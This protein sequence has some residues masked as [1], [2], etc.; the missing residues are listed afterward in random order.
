MGREDIKSSG[1]ACLTSWLEPLAFDTCLLKILA[2]PHPREGYSE[3]H[4]FPDVSNG[5]EKGLMEC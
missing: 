5:L 1:L 3:R 4:I 2:T